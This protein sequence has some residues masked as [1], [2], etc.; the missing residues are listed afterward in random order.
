MIATAR[1]DRANPL[2]H[3]LD[4]RR[5]VDTS[6]VTRR[7][8]RDTLADVRRVIAEGMAARVRLL[9]AEAAHV[10]AL[11]DESD[12][13]CRCM[14]QRDLFDAPAPQP[15]PDLPAAPSP[16]K[17]AADPAA[18]PPELVPWLRRGRKKEASLFATVSHVKSHGTWFVVIPV[19]M[20]APGGPTRLPVCRTELEAVRAAMAFFGPVPPIPPAHRKQ[21]KGARVPS[22]PA[23]SETARGRKAA[24]KEWMLRRRGWLGLPAIVR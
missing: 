13:D 16:L 12:R 10:A 19:H 15:P 4:A 3:G 1:I 2:L 18:I 23:E 5:H 20:R 11:P 9:D 7:W 8:A 17:G 14:G 6:T 21:G 24:A 22:L